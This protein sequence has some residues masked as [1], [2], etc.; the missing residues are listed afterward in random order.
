MPTGSHAEITSLKDL[1]T[2]TEGF[3]PELAAGA[4]VGLV[5]PLGA[6]KTTFVQTVARTLGAEA[7]V[8]S[9]TFTLRQSYP[10][11]H[12]ANLQQIVHVDL[13]RLPEGSDLAATAELGLLDDWQDPT[14]LVLIEWV[15]RMPDLAQ[16]LTHRLTF[17]WNP[18][19]DRRTITVEK[20]REEQ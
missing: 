16:H 5:G 7:I 13:Y 11:V 3:L 8:D 2:W 17:A 10:V 1:A 15:D 20:L 18:A 4:R 14:A 19:S 12:P 6:G 9:P